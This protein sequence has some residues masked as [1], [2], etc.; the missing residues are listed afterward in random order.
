MSGMKGREGMRGGEVDRM[1][2]KDDE[3]GS[4]DGDDNCGGEGRN[5]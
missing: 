5:V 3:E 1:G 4:G 2:R